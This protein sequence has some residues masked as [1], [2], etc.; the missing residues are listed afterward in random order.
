M[1]LGLFIGRK[2]RKRH[3]YYSSIVLLILERSGGIKREPLIGAELARTLKIVPK[4]ILKN[5]LLWHA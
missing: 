3:Y 4:I 2:N 5:C 1:K